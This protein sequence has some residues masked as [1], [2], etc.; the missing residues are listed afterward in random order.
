MRIFCIGDIVGKTGRE[1]IYKHLDCLKKSLKIDFVIANGENASHGRG[2]TRNSFEELSS[3][4]IEVFT[5]G[6]HSW[7]CK[8]IINLLQ[9][10]ERLVRPANFTSAAPGKGYTIVTAANGAKI[11][12]INIIGRTFMDPADSPFT[13]VDKCID[14]ILKQ[15]KIIFV[16]FHA[17]ATSEKGAMAWYLNGRVSAV[18][19]THTHV[20][21]ADDM[22]LTKGTGFISDLGMTGPLYSILGQ[23]RQ[24]IVDRFTTGMPQKFMV[25]TG[26]G[27]LCGCVFDIDPQTGICTGTERI[28]IKE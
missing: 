14:E 26:K 20:Q 13:A 28:Y 4:G 9:Y 2:I 10:E 3:S 21:T 7:G 12:V 27:Q 23:E 25:A 24:T 19:G 1:M 15:T 5:L 6:N 18:F 16:D 22:I 8:D 11:G 17:E